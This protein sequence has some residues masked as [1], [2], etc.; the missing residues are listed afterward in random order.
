VVDG[1]RDVWRW[2]VARSIYLPI[3]GGRY[4]NG[5]RDPSSVHR[6]FLKN[7]ASLGQQKP[8]TVVS[9]EVRVRVRSV[10]K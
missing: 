9:N 4:F 1:G 5:K 8:P 10:P 2:S 3:T 6:D 7:S